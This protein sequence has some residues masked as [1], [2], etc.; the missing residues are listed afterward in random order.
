MAKKY[1]V[2]SL[3]EKCSEYLQNNLDPSNVFSI[4]PTAKKFEEK[5][6]ADRCWNVVDKETEAAVKSDGF[7]IID[8]SL[9][10]AVVSRDTL[11]IEE[12]DL[13]K[14]VE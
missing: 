11:T 10:E 9:L 8:R 4:L 6:L 2:P 5:E 13:F 12:I 7:A 1:I 14:G 3:A